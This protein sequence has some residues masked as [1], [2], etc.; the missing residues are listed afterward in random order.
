MVLGILVETA[1]LSAPEICEGVSIVA[2]NTI[3]KIGRRLAVGMLSEV[4]SQASG[5]V[6]SL[7]SI[8]GSSETAKKSPTASSVDNKTSDILMSTLSDLH[9]TL[10]DQDELALLRQIA[11]AAEMK[12]DDLK[13]L[14][15]K[16][17]DFYQR[18]QPSNS[19]D[20]A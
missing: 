13:T 19:S 17:S 11:V 20:D 18:K 16:L 9:V 8:F 14:L 5:F 3:E 2:G 15:E 4:S 12:R 7:G 6:P 10:V 1:L